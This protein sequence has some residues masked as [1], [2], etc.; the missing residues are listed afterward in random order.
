MVGLGR[1][2][3]KP[4]LELA[5]VLAVLVFPPVFAAPQRVYAVPPYYPWQTVVFFV[6]CSAWLLGS[7]RFFAKPPGDSGTSPEPARNVPGSVPGSVRKNALYAIICGAVLGAAALLTQG[8]SRLTGTSPEMTVQGAWQFSPW[9]FANNLLGTFAAASF[10]EILYRVYLPTRLRCLKLPEYGA[11][12]IALALFAL[13]H[14]PLGLWGMANA[15]LCGA[16]LWF[17]YK[18]TGSVPLICGLH[19]VY[20]I[21]GRTIL[22]YQYVLIATP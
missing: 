21:V 20:N 14:G 1:I 3:K 5:A 4:L 6:L 17:C 9:F 15:L 13:A 12:A 19:T 22:F 11:S 2:Q 7:L 16:A 18:K 8:L 10:E